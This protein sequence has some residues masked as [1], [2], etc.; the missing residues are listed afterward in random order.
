MSDYEN[1]LAINQKLW[2]DKVDH[3]VNSEFYNMAGFINGQS[4]LKFVETELLGAVAGK[5]ILHLQC[6]FG[7]DSISMAR[8]GAKVT[9]VDFSDKAIAQA[10]KLAQKLD[11]TTQFVCCDVY[12]SPQHLNKKFDLVFT[13]YGTIGWLPDVKKWA[14]VISHFLKPGGHLVFVEFHPVV[15]MMDEQ[16]NT[17][18]HNYFNDAPIVERTEGTYADK[19][20]DLKNESISWNHG[21]AE[22]VQALL[23]AGLN[24][25]HLKEY[26]FSPY[27]CFDNIVETKPGQWQVKGKEGKLPMLYSLVATKAI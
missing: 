7:Q 15:W 19:D 21:L 18:T 1:Y 10:K 4:S 16:F 26:D 24:V 9:G 17:I 5:N 2:N 14:D 13:S 25:T 3:H 6:H 23:D 27:P 20:A 11:V 12:D 22:V 8:M